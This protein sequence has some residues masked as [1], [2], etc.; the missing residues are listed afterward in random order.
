VKVIE[1]LGPGCAKCQYTERVVRDVVEASGVPAE[2]LYVTEYGEIAA[3]GVMSTPAITVDGKLV[4]AGRVP[5]REQ[6]RTWLG[7]A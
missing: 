7:V 4:L 3:R 2:I 6:L 1:V 5:T